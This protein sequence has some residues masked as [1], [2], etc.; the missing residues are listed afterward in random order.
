MNLNRNDQ[1]VFSAAGRSYGLMNDS[2]A[3]SS[4]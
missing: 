1:G 3:V 4:L 2:Y